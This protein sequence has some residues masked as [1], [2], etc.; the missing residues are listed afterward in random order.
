MEVINYMDMVRV[1]Q[2]LSWREKLILVINK[3][4]LICFISAF[5][6]FTLLCTA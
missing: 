5:K 6:A 2:V 3:D 1:V 4:I